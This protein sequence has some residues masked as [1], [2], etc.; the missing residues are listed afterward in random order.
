MPIGDR[1]VVDVLIRIRTVVPEA[2]RGQAAVEGVKKATTQ[3][4]QSVDAF[5]KSVYESGRV[6]FRYTFYAMWFSQILQAYLGMRLVRRFLDATNAMED[7]LARLEAISGATYEQIEAAREF[8]DELSARVPFAA[9]EIV[10]ALEAGVRA[11]LEL[12]QAMEVVRSST[13]LALAEGTSLAEATEFL[14]QAMFAFGLSAERV[15]EALGMIFEAARQS[16]YVFGQVTYALRLTMASASA[17]NQSLESLLALLSIFGRAGVPAAQAATMINQTMTRLGDPETMAFIETLLEY[18]AAIPEVL[19]RIGG[20]IPVLFDVEKG[21][22]DIGEAMIGAAQTIAYLREQAMAEGWLGE[23]DRQLMQILYRV[24]GVRNIRAF[25]TLAKVS[26][27]EYRELR[28]TI[29]EATGAVE[30][31]MQRMMGSWEVTRRMASES[32]R[33]VMRL[34]GTGM[35]SVFHPVL[36]VVSE[37]LN[38][39]FLIGRQMPLVMDVVGGFLGIITTVGT[40][41]AVISSFTLALWLLQARLQD[42]GELVKETP[43]LFAKVAGKVPPG[44]S[45]FMIGRYFVFGRFMPILRGVLSVAVTLALLFAGWRR[46]LQ[47]TQ[48]VLSE[49][50]ETL[51]QMPGPVGKVATAI[52]RWF[53]LARERPQS[54]LQAIVGG[55][56]NTFEATL[57]ALVRLVRWAFGRVVDVLRFS[58][59]AMGKVLHFIFYPLALVVGGGDAQRGYERL[60]WFLQNVVG[61]ILGLALFGVAVGKAIDTVKKVFGWVFGFFRYLIRGY[62]LGRYIRW[63]GLFRIFDV[64]FGQGLRLMYSFLRRLWHWVNLFRVVASQL[65]F[66]Q[67]VRMFFAMGL[68][69]IV[70]VFR[71]HLIVP[72]LNYLRTLYVQAIIPL[73]LRIKE[74]ILVVWDYI[75][76]LIL[77]KIL[78]RTSGTEGI[79]SGWGGALAGGGLGGL[80]GKLGTWLGGLFGKLGGFLGPLLAKFWW[81]FPIIAALGGLGYGLY[82][83]FTRP[84]QEAPR[85]PTAPTG[86]LAPA[87]A[88][89]MNVSI[90]PT[91]IV[92]QGTPAEQA[93]MIMQELE[94][95]LVQFFETYAWRKEQLNLER[96]ERAYG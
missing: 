2:D 44:A 28:Q 23:F 45:A 76:A 65:G 83:L 9:S 7:A 85:V 95:R 13:A 24:F 87:Y 34:V 52:G 75:K 3:A 63:P 26:V 47:G 48:G 40:A 11:G 55:I 18:G 1:S 62:T 43:E 49:I 38:G 41:A 14:S 74:L 8:A 61:G 6:L 96:Q 4:R 71:T 39:F 66:W 53:R 15:G 57:A 69:K 51:E 36:R 60:Y 84:R 70:Q 33:N 64:A 31:Y 27:A 12:G 78:K 17:L 82:R 90:S 50:A 92:P 77:E 42:I 37:L 30:E 73:I 59:E 29:A 81:I 56:Y 10:K 72:L 94:G 35:L 88:T 68:S 93:E 58:L 46:N 19:E 86:L 22:G 67:A 21:L 54:A 5:N 79:I 20:E 80:F 25:L 16:P 91:I 32:V 89:T